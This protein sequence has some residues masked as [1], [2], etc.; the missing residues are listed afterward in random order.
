MKEPDDGELWSAIA[1]GDPDAFGLLFERHARRI[2][3]Y[4][5][6]RTADKARAED[7]T[8]MVF[9]ECWRRRAVELEGEK[10]LPWLYGIATNVCRHE[11]RSLRRHRAALARLPAATAEPDV[12]E[13]TVERLGDERD[14]RE[15]LALVSRLPQR[16][17][18]VLALCVWSGLSYQEAAS[19]L[20][21]PIGTVRSRLA[22]A[23]ARLQSAL[24][25]EHGMRAQRDVT[26]DFVPDKGVE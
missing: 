16:E 12:A 20:G 9:L 5:F 8:S 11:R 26:P 24:E 10:V 13:A 14:M 17:Q 21:V 6:R 23:R 7:L 25:T 4:C 3:A 2:F 18:D 19:A 22:R 15:V 1:R